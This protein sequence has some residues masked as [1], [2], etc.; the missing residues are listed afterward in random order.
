MSLAPAP[1]SSYAQ[2]RLP[3]QQLPQM[4]QSTWHYDASFLLTKKYAKFNKN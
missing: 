1:H 4:P 2:Q 3:Q